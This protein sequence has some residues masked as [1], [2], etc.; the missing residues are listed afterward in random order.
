MPQRLLHLSKVG[1]AG[2][3]EVQ[4]MAVA[5]RAEASVDR[6][7]RWQVSLADLSILV[8]AAGLAAG[9]ARGARNIWGYWTSPWGPTSGVPISRPVGV[10][11]V[12]VAVWFA[13]ILARGIIAL[14][15][16]RRS[17]VDATSPWLVV[18]M[19]WRSLALMLMLSF[20]MRESW[21]LRVDYRDFSISSSI[22]VPL[23]LWYQVRETLIPICAILAMIGLALGVGARPFFARNGPRRRRP[24]W[25]F[26][27]LVAL[28][29]VLFLGQS[30]SVPSLIPALILMAIEAVNN[31]AR[32]TFRMNTADLPERLMLAGFEAI[33]AA[34]ACLWLALVV[35]RDFERTRRD[36]PWATTPRGWILRILSLLTVLAAGA[37][38]ATVAIR[39]IHPFYFDA[40]RKLLDGEI[41][42]FVLA[43]FA[44]FSA[45]LAARTMVPAAAPER[46]MRVNGMAVVA[47]VGLTAIGVI[48]GLQCLPESSQLGPSVPKI[49]GRVCDLAREFPAWIWSLL[50]DSSEIIL[51][52][53]FEPE[54][55]VWFLAVSAVCLLVFEVALPRRLRGQTA[56]FDLVLESPGRLAR[57]SWLTMALTAVCIVA[58]PTLF[59]LGQV[60]VYLR[61]RLGDWMAR[62]WQ[63]PF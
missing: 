14:A 49:I 17:A 55:I 12:V 32:P 22:E 59:V 10:V 4:S 31:A 37:F 48:S 38:V 27:P 52:G 58:V 15:R 60:I 11:I 35:A 2:I 56:P 24:Y 42:T 57:F 9:I 1:E 53:W 13:M 34:V 51:P 26:V 8:L 16:G 36:E 61:L 23:E 41:T 63:W 50:P 18:S 5:P 3:V 40:F 29:A 43:G 54:R 20:A 19:A 6:V 44:S 62:G 33:P 28:A 46:P 7:A 45:G 47:M 21:I 25:L 30:A 39:T